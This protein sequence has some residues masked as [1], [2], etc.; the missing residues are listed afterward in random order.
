MSEKLLWLLHD[1]RRAK[2]HG[3]AALAQRQRARFTEL[4]AFARA[5]SPYYRELY[6][7]LPAQI[8]DP[9]LLPVT[10]K[11]TLMARVDDWVTNRDVTIEQ[12]R[13]FV[14]TPDLVGE[15]L[16]GKYAVA[17]TSGTT[18]TRGIF[19]MDD[20]ALAVNRAL[21][22]R[23]ISAWL[24][25]GDLMRLLA[26]GRR[27]AA[28][29]ATGGHFISLVNAARLRKASRWGGKD[30]EV[31]SVHTPL[32]ELV[33]QLN[34]FR[35][36]I[37]AGYA[38]MIA[39]LA[40]EQEAGR[41]HIN[42]V[43]VVPG[44][45]GLAAGEYERIARV[46]NTKVRNGY[47]ATEC[48]LSATAASTAGCTSTATGV[49]EPVDADYQ[50]TSPGEASHTVL[51]SNLANQ[52]Q[53]ILRYDLG[54][55]IVWRPDL[56]PCGDPLPAIRVQGRAADVLTFKSEGGEQVAIAPLAFGTLVDRT[57]GVEL[58]QIV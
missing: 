9:T 12:V 34:R 5:N 44:A 33:A 24:N 21:T 54:D 58:F 46:F 51:L 41:L 36:G 37:L 10:S 11:K 47:A 35:A 22:L 38:S 23:M 18:G 20:R 1:T 29:I 42:P 16:L 40:G 45:E 17:T 4:V 28:L 39:L 57:P 3:T 56:C 7:N 30:I 13:A 31:F 26:G 52:V 48:P 6:Q 19:L 15:R 32:P 50:P 25:S 49:F 8:D 53:P 27:A 14:D 43:L 55:S 2:K